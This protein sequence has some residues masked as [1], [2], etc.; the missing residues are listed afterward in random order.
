MLTIT[1]LEFGYDSRTRQIRELDLHLDSGALLGL[2]G[3]NGAGKTTLVS[4][5]AGLLRADRGQILIDGSPARLGR[6]DLALVPQEYAF[7][8]R[9]TGREN[10]YY[11]AGVLGLSGPQKREAVSNALR[12][13]DL[14][15]VQTQRAGRYSGGTKRRLNF[16]IALLQEP[17]LLILD[18][19]TANVDPQSR[20]FLLDEVRQLNRQGTTIIYTSHLLQEVESLCDTLALMDEGRLVAAGPLQE[21][22]AQ[23]KRRLLVA[24]NAAPPPE[25]AAQTDAQQ[26]Q[27][28]RW[29]FNPEKAGLTPVQLLARL[30]A[31][32]LRVE[33]LQ[34]GQ[35]RLEELFFATTRRELRD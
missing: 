6:R 16:A 13:C 4:L 30:E 2:L 31:S 28:G 34:Y 27:D 9:L 18:E 1:G 15:R 23:Q 20:A 35:A 26:T 33:Q 24:L 29:E 8:P 10:L 12:R 21:L 32:G 22:L 17:K 25:L 3:P 11:F 5:I 19:P 14:E 7:Y